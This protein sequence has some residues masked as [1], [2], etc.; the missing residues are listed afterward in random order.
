M[1]LTENAQV[2]YTV[3]L[4]RRRGNMLLC[5]TSPS[6]ESMV[7]AF[8]MAECCYQHSIECCW[9]SIPVRENPTEWENLLRDHRPRTAVISLRQLTDVSSSQ[10]NQHSNKIQNTL[11]TMPTDV[12][13]SKH[14]LCDM[15][16][17]RSLIGL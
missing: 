16:P 13:V 17:Q 4:V 9:H 5:Y 12:S 7:P 1:I 10:T 11:H 3:G 8:N 2:Y 14:L 15:D 6:A